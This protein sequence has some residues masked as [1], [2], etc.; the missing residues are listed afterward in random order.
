MGFT[1]MPIADED[2]HSFVDGEVS[3]ERYEAVVAY[4]AA[5]PADAARVE[6]W[7]QQNILLRAAFAQ[8]T[9]EPV[10]M[11]LSF[12]FAPRLISLRPFAAADGLGR[13]TDPRRL[14]HRSLAF[15]VAAFVAGAC[16]ALAA[17]FSMKRY[18]EFTK[19]AAG[20]DLAQ[21]ATAALQHPHKAHATAR[22]TQNLPGA[23]EPALALLPVLKSEG[24]QLQRGEVR[25]TARAPAHC[26]DF[27]DA[28]GAPVVLCIAAADAPTDPH[29]Q[30][31]AVVS[32]HSVYWREA[33]S[34][35]ALAAPV[36]GDRL[37]A[38]ARH[39]HAALAHDPEKQ[40]DFSDK[41]MR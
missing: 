24:L 37:V 23:I 13:G 4:L 8:V 26:L 11:N 33:T 38:L 31:L 28:A 20:P 39:I 3:D 1:S 19:A 25:G 10:P 36:A 5:A 30:G 12:S 15:T 6:V 29:F 34:L 18:N 35:Y 17:D 9:L 14:R 27:A 16:I 2:L 21:L 7:R 22:I 32:A 40:T 41:I